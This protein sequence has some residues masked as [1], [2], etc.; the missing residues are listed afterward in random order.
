MTLSSM[1][2]FARAD[3]ETP[4]MRWTCEARSVNNRGLDIRSRLPP[5]FESLET[6]IRTLVSERFQRGSI[7]LTLTLVRN[8]TAE[9]QVRLN[10]NVLAQILTAVRAL[11]ETPG[12]QPPSLDGLLALKG[13][14][15]VEEQEESESERAH[16]EAALLTGIAQALDRLKVARR[17]EGQHLS[18]IVS[19]QIGRIETLTKAA[20][21][22]TGNLK[23]VM[24]ARLREQVAMLLDSGA[25]DPARLAQEVALLATRADITEELDRLMAHVAQARAL[26]GD[27]QPVGRKLDFLTQEFN[28]EAN[29]LCS[30][31]ALGE[32]TRIGL[33]LKAVIDQLR[34]QVQNVE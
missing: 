18:E 34:E 1:T 33:E 29:T 7:Q 28:R 10:Q 8:K 30:K 12:V 15:D 3:G 25:P 13:V 9:P 17:A 22:E 4:D 27:G 20:R 23:E 26:L 21:A 14:L 16:R 6:A 24:R 19:Q 5:R 11:Q 31:S 2:G 32:L